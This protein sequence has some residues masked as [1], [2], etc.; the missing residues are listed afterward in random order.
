MVINESAFKSH[1]AA[2]TDL[3]KSFFLSS[4]L[5]YKLLN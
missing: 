5:Y 4:Q 3:H 1:Y 2:K